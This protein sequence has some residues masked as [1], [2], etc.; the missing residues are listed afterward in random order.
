VAT[1]PEGPV[2]SK[3]AKV[4]IFA[5]IPPTNRYAGSRQGMPVVTGSVKTE[6]RKKNLRSRKQDA[7]IVLR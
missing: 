3:Y 4:L 1:V 7:L 2:E 6:S 5:E